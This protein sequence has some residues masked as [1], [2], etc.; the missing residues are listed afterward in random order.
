MNGGNTGRSA[1]VSSV[2]TNESVVANPYGPYPSSSD[3]P[4]SVR[5]RLPPDAQEVFRAAYNRCLQE[6]EDVEHA[7]RMAWGAVARG[8]RESQD[9]TWVARTGD[10][11]TDQAPAEFLQPRRRRAV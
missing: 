3:L 5:R 8:Y 6:Y 1:N 2:M 7:G 4:P 10:P 9:G 11:E